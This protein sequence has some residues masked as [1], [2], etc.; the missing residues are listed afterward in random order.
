MSDAMWR[1]Q[2]NSATFFFFSF[3]TKEAIF[4]R[5]MRNNKNVAH[6]ILVGRYRKCLIL[7]DVEAKKH[8]SNLNLNIQQAVIHANM[9]KIQ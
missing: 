5:F 8:G 6:C 1:E 9:L 7:L 4:Q 3:F 2:T